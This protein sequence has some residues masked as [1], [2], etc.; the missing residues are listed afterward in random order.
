MTEMRLR[1]K[2]AASCL[3]YR[4]ARFQTTFWVSDFTCCTEGRM[5]RVAEGDAPGHLNLVHYVALASLPR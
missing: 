4:S 5:N 3:G 2:I 1:S